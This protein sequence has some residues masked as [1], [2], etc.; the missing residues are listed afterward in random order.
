M[1][2]L[3]SSNSTYSSPSTGSNSPIA[4]II[5][6][7]GSSRRLPGDTPKQWRLLGGIP[8]V[9]HSF[10]F[11]DRCS[12]IQQICVAVD[13]E[14]LSRP[15]RL[16]YLVSENDRIVRFT[17]GGLHR[18]QTVWLALQTLDPVPEIVLIHD[19]A[20]PFPPLSGVQECI[21]TA[22][23]S[24]GAILAQPVIET[25]KRVNEK[26]EIIDTIDRSALWGAQTPQGFR[27][28]PLMTSYAARQNDLEQ[29]TDD[30]GIF[31]ANGGRVR[32]VR[33]SDTNFKITTPE[34]I[35]RAEQILANQ[36]QRAV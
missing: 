29:F 15:D 10:R 25:I 13:A 14:S 6:A 22:R 2:M 33:G 21:E 30:A 28:E 9:A 35:V 24:G 8:L 7:A 17:A 1:N 4:V 11:F 18:Q 3:Q 5:V 20:R 27:F 12:F 26:L 31:E 32:V 36:K 19:A 34:D 23:A 16:H